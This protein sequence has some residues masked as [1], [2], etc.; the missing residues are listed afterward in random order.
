DDAARAGNVDAMSEEIAE[1]AVIG[2]HLD[3][4]GARRAEPAQDVFGA[5]VQIDCQAVA[6]LKAPLEQPAR[7]SRG[8]LIGASIGIR[9]VSGI[10]VGLDDER[11]VAMAL[12]LNAQ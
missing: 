5:V 3:H 6:G 9:A 2:G 1:V 10:A 7:Y 4:A 12:G 8:E 11:L